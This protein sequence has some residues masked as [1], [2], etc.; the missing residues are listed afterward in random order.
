MCYAFRTKYPEADR[1]PGQM[2]FLTFFW[3]PI[4]IAAGI[5]DCH[6][7]LG[8]EEQ[9]EFLDPKY[10]KDKSG[11]CWNGIYVVASAGSA[12]MGSQIDKKSGSL[13]GRVLK[14]PF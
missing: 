8:V 13:R 10:K 7:D 1:N 9:D 5:P 3:A 12:A 11:A 6:C 2:E 14:A 4:A